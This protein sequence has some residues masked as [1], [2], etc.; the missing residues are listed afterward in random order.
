MK[1]YICKGECKGVSEVQCNCQAQDC[2]LHSIPLEECNCTDGKHNILE[3][4]N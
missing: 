2:N 3:G 1:H 4:K